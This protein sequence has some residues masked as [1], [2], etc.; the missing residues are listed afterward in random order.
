MRIILAIVE[1]Q[2]ASTNSCKLHDGRPFSV[3][4]ADQ[5]PHFGTLMPLRWSAHPIAY[6][7]L[8]RQDMS[9]LAHKMRNPQ[10]SIAARRVER[11]EKAA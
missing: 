8:A 2:R 4:V 3:Q 7:V 9:W 6:G 10:N 11:V 5:H 1:S